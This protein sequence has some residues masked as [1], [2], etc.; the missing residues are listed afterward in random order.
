[1]LPDLFAAKVVLLVW[2]LGGGRRLEQHTSHVFVLL[3]YNVHF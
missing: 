1:M 2:L 3:N